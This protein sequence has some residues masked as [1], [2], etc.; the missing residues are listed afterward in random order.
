ML[1]DA[2]IEPSALKNRNGEIWTVDK[3]EAGCIMNRK[4]NIP[5]ALHNHICDKK[6]HDRLEK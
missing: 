3:A 4:K 1:F 6:I 2:I 5:K